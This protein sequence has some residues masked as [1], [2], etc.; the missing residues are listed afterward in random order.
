MKIQSIA[1]EG[2]HKV[3]NIS[4]DFSNINYLKGPN[5]SGKST[6]LQAI[7]LAL[8]GYIPGTKKTNESIFQHSNGRSM[9]VTLVLDDNGQTVIVTR[10]WAKMSSVISS[11]NILPVGYDL[12]SVIAEIE[13]P[14]FNFNEFTGLTANKLKDWFIDFLPSTEEEINWNVVLKTNL[15]DNNIDIED[16]TIYNDAIKY[17][18]GVGSTGLEAVRAANAYFKECVSFKKSE[19]ARIKNTIQSLIHYEDIDMSVDE[20][21]LEAE[22]AQLNKAQSDVARSI[23]A[24]GANENI[25]TQLKA[26][27]N[28]QDTLEE[29][30]GYISNAQYITDVEYQITAARH[31]YD[32]YVSRKAAAED[33]IALL[34]PLLDSMN[35]E[36]VCPYVKKACEDLSSI[37]SDYQS[38]ID[39]AKATIQEM[40]TNIDEARTALNA[41]QTKQ[42]SARNAIHQLESNYKQR[43]QLKASLVEVPEIDSQY[44]D[45]DAIA[46]RIAYVQDLLIKIRANKSY[47]AMISKLTAE[48]IAIDTELAAYKSWEKLTGVN[49][50]QSSSGEGSPLSVF[51]DQITKYVSTFFGKNTKAGFNVE[52]KANS[53][54]FGV[55]RGDDYIPYDLLS[56]GEKCLYTLALMCCI[57]NIAKSPLKVLIVDDMLDHLDDKNIKT[58]FSTLKKVSD[59][60]MIFAGVKEVTE[61][62]IN[63]MEVK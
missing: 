46:T 42:S 48:S 62:S 47:D 58:V 24:R 18:S 23:A 28:L 19:S 31:Q 21:S 57:V 61:E 6:V 7:Q 43:D 1:I 29:D 51:S 14:I 60:Q 56:S 41:L 59:I 63:I 53:F 17:L 22:L 4:Y 34:Q 44:T 16:S 12:K 52:Q 49:G 2:L 45:N 54:N 35:S 8:L 30:P 9:S 27:E 55:F 36:G 13:L 32:E 11:V 3:Q 50:L 26:F 15:N 39:M 37:I 40:D 33:A 10:T 25:L 20:A 5:G 38:K